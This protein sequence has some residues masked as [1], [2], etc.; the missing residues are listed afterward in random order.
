MCVNRAPRRGP[1]PRRWAEKQ[2]APG[3]AEPRRR[4]P[5]PDADPC[6]FSATSNHA[7]SGQVEDERRPRATSIGDPIGL[8]VITR[9]A[10]AGDR[11][12]PALVPTTGPSL[13]ASILRPEAE[14]SRPASRRAPRRGPPTRVTDWPEPVEQWVSTGTETRR[15]GPPTMIVRLAGLR[16]RERCRTRVRP[17]ICAPPRRPPV[18]RPA[19]LAAWADRAHVDVD[20]SR[21]PRAGQNFRPGPACGSRPARAVVGD[22]A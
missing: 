9:A 20:L 1:T 10:T 17:S 5:A 8:A 21:R 15:P 14:C 4:W 7:S 2:R 6:A 16:G 18:R 19:R 12:P 13:N 22:H 3:N 11:R